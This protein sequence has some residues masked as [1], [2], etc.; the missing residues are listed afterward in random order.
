MIRFKNLSIYKLPLCVSALLLVSSGCTK[1]FEEYNTNTNQAT[2][3]MLSYDNLSTGTY[4]VQMEKNVFPIAQ[5]PDFGDEVYQTMQNL[6]GD[7]FSGYMGASNNWY[8][9][10]N[11]TTYGL[12]PQ[13]YGQAFNRAFVGIMPAWYKIKVAAQTATPAAYAMATIVKVEALHRT[14]DMYGPLP[15]LSFGN[16]ALQNKYDSQKDIYYKFFDELDEAIQI[17]TDF[18][19]KTPGAT[20]LATY[21]FIYGG[22]V[23]KW[24]KFANSLKLRLAMRLAYADPTKAR[25]MAEAAVSNTIGVIT[26]AADIAALQHSTNLVFNHP[27][28]IISTSFF[29][30]KMGANM[31]SF[32][33]GYK[34][35]REASYFNPVAADGLYHGIRNGIT[36]AAKTTYA[37]GPFSTLNIKAST[38]IVWMNPAEVYFLRAEG[39]L[40]GW[41][42]GGTAQTLYETGIRTSFTVSGVTTAADAYI[43]DG[44]SLPA[45]YSDSKNTA[46]NITATSTSLSKITIKW[47][48]TATTETNLERIITQK[49]ISMYPDGQEAWTEFRRTGYPKVFPVVINNS[50]GLISTTTQIRRLPFPSAEYQT[51]A[52]GVASGISLLGGADNGGTKLW[53]DKK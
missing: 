28:Y 23:T 27:L 33:T 50:Q 7:V 15:Y 53:W 3:Q 52:S 34:D 51:N 8:S 22:N 11:N 6:A 30:I 39:A 13:W 40:R 24:I 1:K 20:S 49:W 18:T 31:E 2:S 25:A 46:N 35:P 29:D 12:V 14:T 36:I 41:S 26:D 42:M 47:D 45:A 43:A 37:D 48:G 10:V 5:P 21:D 19:T 16:G 9:G 44:T 4:F 32:L 38:P 17:L